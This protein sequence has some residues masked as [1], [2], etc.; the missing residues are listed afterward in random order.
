[1]V[2]IRPINAH[3]WR[4]RVAGF[5]E[6]LPILFIQ[7]GTELRSP[8]ALKCFEKVLSIKAVERRS[9]LDHVRVDPC[10]LESSIVGHAK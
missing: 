7:E 10:D 9:S 2:K 8:I 1:V 6:L 3:P 4:Q 5:V